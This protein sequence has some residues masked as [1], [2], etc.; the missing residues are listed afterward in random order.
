MKKILASMLVFVSC[1]AALATAAPIDEARAL[2]ARYVELEKSFDP[3]VAD[4]YADDAAITNKRKYPGGEVRILSMPVAKY[5][6][7][8]R[9]TMPI[10]QARDDVSTYL[11]VTYKVEGTGVRIQGTR[12][13]NLKKYSS[14]ISLLVGPN[15]KGEWLIRE[16]L[17]ESQP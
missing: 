7:L 11:N 13:S 4:L 14:P 6:Q 16:E 1:F 12:F 3:A 10:A 9:Q 5:K 8:I 15:N 2:F 17:S